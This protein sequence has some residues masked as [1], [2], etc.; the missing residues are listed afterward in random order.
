MSLRE[1]II[2]LIQIA[3]LFAFPAIWAWLL[4]IFPGW[5]LDPE[6]TL[7]LLVYLVIT[8]VSWLLG[9]LGIRR[10]ITQLR[11]KGLAEDVKI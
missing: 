11:T 1:L 10:F 2:Q 3:L 8:L 4:K 6:S 5:P 9:Y 7:N